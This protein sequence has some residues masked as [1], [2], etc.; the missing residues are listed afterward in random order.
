MFS[1]SGSWISL[2][3]TVKPKTAKFIIA[4]TNMKI[5]FIFF[6]VL[7]VETISNTYQFLDETNYSCI[8]LS[9]VMINFLLSAL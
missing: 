3:S 2:G 8:I 7:F 9:S 6:T 4:H 5:P 1:I